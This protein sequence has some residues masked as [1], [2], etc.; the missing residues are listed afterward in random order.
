MKLGRPRF[1]RHSRAINIQE[2]Q[3]LF[4]GRSHGDNSFAL[5]SERRE[6]ERARKGETTSWRT[7]ALFFA[8]AICVP[9]SFPP[10][11][12]HSAA[13]CP[14]FL[15]P[16]ARAC[17][18]VCM[19]MYVC[20]PTRSTARSTSSSSSSSFRAATKSSLV[21]SSSLRVAKYLGAFLGVV[22]I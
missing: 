6:M 1:N 22:T 5:R 13:F 10:P 7:R 12:C 16:R 21:S 2:T 8:A 20:T 19:C 15:F 14:C 3:M 4:Y 17:A 18:R 11:S 9:P